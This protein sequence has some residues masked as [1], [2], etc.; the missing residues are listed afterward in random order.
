MPTQIQTL[1][2]RLRSHLPP[3]LGLADFD[4]YPALPSTKTLRNMRSLR[5]VPDGLFVRDGKR[6]LVDMEGFLAWWGARLTPENRQ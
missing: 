2:D 5:A 1:V 3:I 6:V 4:Q